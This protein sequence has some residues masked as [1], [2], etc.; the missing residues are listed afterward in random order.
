MKHWSGVAR[1]AL[2]HAERTS[3]WMRGRVTVRHVGLDR[4]GEYVI[5]I[6]VPA[7]DYDGALD[8]LRRAL[9]HDR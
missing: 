5:E 3:S 9:K 2:D 1:E 8:A 6:R 4:D 7:G